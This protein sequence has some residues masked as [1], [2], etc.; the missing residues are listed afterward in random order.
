MKSL[1]CDKRAL[2]A[3]IRTVDDINTKTHRPCSSDRL[4]VC[5]KFSERNLIV[6]FGYNSR[7][8]KSV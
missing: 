8:E 5:T 2:S 6:S 4:G 7:P 3:E 1:D